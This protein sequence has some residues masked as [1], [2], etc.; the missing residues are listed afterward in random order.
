MSPPVALDTRVPALLLRLDRNPF[1]H[2]SLGAVRSLGRAGVEAHAFVESPTVPLARSRYLAAA[3]RF[4]GDPR[5]VDDVADALLAAA[6]RI[7]R[8]AVLIPM[9]DAGALALAALADRLE[10]HFLFPRLPAG[11]AERAAD[12][13]RLAELCAALD[14]PH[15][16]T[17]VPGSPEEAAAAARELG[18]P[19]VAK[20]SRP[21][22]LPPGSGLRSVTLVRSAAQAARLH[23]RSGSAGGELLLQRLLPAG[24][25]GTD[26]FFHG[27]F[28]AGG[29]PLLTG[30]GHKEL[31]WP[32]R[33]GLTAVGGWLPNPAVAEL[34][35]RLAAAVGYH[36]VL[37]LDFRRDARTGVHHLLDFNPRPGAQF[38]LFADRAT[39]LDVV[40]ALHLDLTGRSPVGVSRPRAGRT[41]VVEQ[42]GLLASFAA[43][44]AHWPGSGGREVEWAWS[45]SDDPAPL[46]ALTR[47]WLRR[48]S[49]RRTGAGR[50]PTT[51]VE[52]TE[53]PVEK[54]NARC[55]TW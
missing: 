32:P 21:W 51:S 39:G 33:A 36:G 26:W 10:G 40:R 15:P 54:E 3:H 4:R 50:F 30:T 22:L 11:L 20:W 52:R 19:A 12:K 1:H 18:L 38:R 41:F 9:D 17:L 7:G 14:I 13:A 37:D 43:R 2:G 49:T 44:R 5:S 24:G 25:A 29:R 47:H 42:Y 28:A 35:G 53:P 6:A 48:A 55:T 8:P 23:A 45:A 27:C 34:A 16:P 46:L 31:S